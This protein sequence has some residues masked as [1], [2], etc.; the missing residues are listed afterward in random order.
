MHEA[1]VKIIY[2]PRLISQIPVSYAAHAFNQF[3][4]SMHLFEIVRLCA[5]WDKPREDRESIPTIICLVNKE[6]LIE[7]LMQETFDFHA[8]E[9]PPDNLHSSMS[10]ED[11]E[12]IK[13]WWAQDRKGFASKQAE[14]IRKYFLSR[15]IRLQKFKGLHT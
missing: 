3:Q 15:E 8:N 7:Q 12:A 13:A 4:S 2:S 9:P 10:P 11:I 14:T 6:E 5:L 1:N